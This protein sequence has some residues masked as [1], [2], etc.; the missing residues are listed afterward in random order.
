MPNQ[1][2]EIDRLLDEIARLVMS[3]IREAESGFP[4]GWVPATHVKEQL[5]L[6]RESYP[7]GN[8][9]QGRT[10]WLFAIL[11]RILEEQ[12]DVEF[13]KKGNRSYYRPTNGDT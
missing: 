7:V 1:K 4:G 5:G 10:G 11:A 9:I 3:Y 6:K 8:E 13:R 2:Q 12:V